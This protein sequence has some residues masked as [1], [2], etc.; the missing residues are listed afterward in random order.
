MEAPLGEDFTWQVPFYSTVHS[1]GSDLFFHILCFFFNV[2]QGLPPRLATKT[3]SYFV[4]CLF[5]MS[6]CRGCPQKTKKKWEE[7]CKHRRRYGGDVR[8]IKGAHARRA[9]PLLETRLVCFSPYGRQRGGRELGLRRAPT[10]TPPWEFH[11]GKQLG[12]KSN[13]PNKGTQVH[14]VRSQRRGFHK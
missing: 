7:R 14:L 5:L 1:E 2:F 10:T 11:P 4:N 12:Y 6:Q 3:V 8:R 13:Q 9:V